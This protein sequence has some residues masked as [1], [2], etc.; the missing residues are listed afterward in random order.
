MKK[1][2]SSIRPILKCIFIIISNAIF[3]QGI[4]IQVKVLDAQHTPIEVGN[5]LLLSPVDS[6][7]LS[8]ELFY[9]GKI[10]WRTTISG[11]VL[12]KI[13][14]L[15]YADYQ[16]TIRLQE[17][18]LDL[19]TVFLEQ[20]TLEE[21]VV[22]GRSQIVEQKNGALVV[23]IEN[24]TLENMGSAMDVLRNT[25]KVSLARGNQVEVI[26][27]GKALIYLD[28][29]LITS[30]Q[31]L[32][33]LA[34]TDLK[35]IEV[36]ENPSAKY[37]AAGQAI[38]NIQTKKKTLEGFKIGLTQEV[39]KGQF[40]RALSNV[41]A[42]YRAGKFL[43]QAAYGYSPAKFWMS[44]SYGRT[45]EHLGKT[46]MI[47]NKYPFTIARQRHQYNFKTLFQLSEKSEIGLN[48]TGNLI[49][50]FR[51]G[52]N[53][54]NYF[55]N[56]DLQFQLNVDNQGPF[57]QQNNIVHLYYNRQLKENGANLS[58]AAQYATYDLER[59]ENIRQVLDRNKS[60]SESIRRT[61]NTNAIQVRSL[62]L[63]YNQPLTQKWTLESGV[64]M[65]NIQNGSLLDFEALE[66]DGTY[67]AFP[68]FS[69]DYTYE[70]NVLALYTQANWQIEKMTA[71]LGLRGEWTMNNGI[72]VKEQGENII[73]NNYQNLFP[74]ASIR[75]TLSEDINLGLNY[76]YR[77]QRPAFQDLNPFTF[78]A[79][80]L[81][82]FR[83][84][85]LLQPEYSHNAGLSFDFKKVNFSLNY[86][87]T[88]D[89]INTIVTIPNED[90]PAIFDF[91]RDNTIST[92]L[93]AANLSFPLQNKWYSSYTTLTARLDDHRF[94]DRELA[95]SNQ[96]FGVDIQ[97][98][99]TFYLPKDFSFEL[100]LK[101]NSPRVDGIY[102]DQS[103]TMVSF[104][105]SRSFLNNALTARLYA[106]DI[107][108]GF[109][110]KG[111]YDVYDNEW[112]YLSE[113]DFRYVK[114][115]LNWNFGKL[116]TNK[117]HNKHLYNSELNRINW[118]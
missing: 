98:N 100:F 101:H 70:E 110:F 42:Y 95:T 67:T 12:F 5:V 79:D 58:A 99:H 76:N 44:N 4:H 9:D 28:G 86:A 59:T 1:Y 40:G 20:N 33:S 41:D 69:T 96:S 105:L 78:F 39:G 91:F 64:K 73:D 38:I 32:N 7:I 57:Q 77:I 118:Q 89:K 34:S 53:R 104:G 19:G 75:A 45:Y 54:N 63:D 47:N 56:G 2:A 82:S 49:D 21:V 14:A 116:G 24:T 81:V 65:A 108:K 37:D 18:P 103:I 80:S 6:T 88:K 111:T 109:R 26:G 15:G 23:N 3:A 48:Y 102:T 16:Q 30:T 50:A 27:K 13:T 8:G 46:I 10:E 61:T 25:P 71:N 90:E 87:Y 60:A 29:Q 107:F 66:T 84:N 43:F 83:G 31:L 93:Y 94:F 85:P 117:L 92:K 22:I 35:A 52:I 51:E 62:Q 11:E 74:S 97:S 72:A 113:G 115:S 112:T 106:N 114:L 68:E 55:E 17:T 36:I